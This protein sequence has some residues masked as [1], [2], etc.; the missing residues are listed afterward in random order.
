M[1]SGSPQSQIHQSYGE[2]IGNV[3]GRIDLA[4]GNITKGRGKN[5]VQKMGMAKGLQHLGSD[6]EMAQKS[7]ARER[8]SFS[9]VSTDIFA[10]FFSCF[11]W[12]FFYIKGDLISHTEDKL[13]SS[14]WNRS[15]IAVKYLH[16]VSYWLFL[17]ANHTVTN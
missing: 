13:T 3:R 12:L 10:C 14:L 11:F 4:Q 8:T 7:S 2:S 15:G 9:T 17:T 6:S 16:I 1:L 5:E